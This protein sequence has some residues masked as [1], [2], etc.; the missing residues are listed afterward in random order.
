[1]SDALK[2]TRR[3]LSDEVFDR[4]YAKLLNGDYAPGESL[5]SERELME[6]FGVGRPAVRE[7]TQALERLG[8][9][10]IHHGQRPRVT[11]PTASGMLSQIDLTARH[12][13]SS[14]PQ[15]LEHLK[16]ARAFFEL[17]MV[18]RATR[19][20]SDEDIARLEGLLETQRIELNRDAG[21]FIQADM[22]FHAAIAAITGNPIFAAV[23]KAM[24]DWLANFHASLLHWKG[25]EHVTLEEHARIL[26]AIKTHDE[27]LAVSE[28]RAHLDRARSLYQL[29]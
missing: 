13:L 5:P 11:L 10:S 15:S 22:A 25:N 28:M 9:V 29:T 20:A 21:A 12:M 27:A 16:E 8:L 4:L 6:L 26:D 19:M 3:K 17:G 23:S 24:L 14:S 1:M 18:A 7:A 2:I